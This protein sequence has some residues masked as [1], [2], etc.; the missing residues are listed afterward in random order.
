MK[1]WYNYKFL[2]IYTLFW[3]YKLIEKAFDCC[4]YISACRNIFGWFEIEGL[5]NSMT[6]FILYRILNFTI[7]LQVLRWIWSAQELLSF[8]SNETQLRLT[9]VIY[10]FKKCLMRKASDGWFKSNCFYDI[11]FGL[12]KSGG[13][14][15]RQFLKLKLLRMVLL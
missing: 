8:I 12:K 10:C 1:W 7:D 5:L 6:Q 15:L 14:Y 2:L 4:N 3:L 11:L 9:F 13:V